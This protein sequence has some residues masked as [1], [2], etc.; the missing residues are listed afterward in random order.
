MLP[1]SV[2]DVEDIERRGILM[3]LSQKP[4]EKSFSA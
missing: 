1:T 3:I 2:E 4:N